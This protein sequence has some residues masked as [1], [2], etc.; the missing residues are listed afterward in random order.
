LLF[1]TLTFIHDPLSF[2]LRLASDSIIFA[3]LFPM[4]KHKKIAFDEEF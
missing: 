1:W 3:P 4:E 2:E